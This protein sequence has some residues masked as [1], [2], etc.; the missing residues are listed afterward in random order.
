MNNFNDDLF[1]AIDNY[2]KN[3][4]KKFNKNNLKLIDFELLKEEDQEND[5]YNYIKGLYYY[6]VLN[7]FKNAIKYYKLSANEG[8]KLALKILARHYLSINDC[9]NAK[10][11]Y[12]IILNKKIIKIEKKLAKLYY[13]NNNLN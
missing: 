6:Y 5:W 1:D 7:D 10:Y 11:Y 9:E 12:E 8:N 4:F 3:Y 13:R 2:D